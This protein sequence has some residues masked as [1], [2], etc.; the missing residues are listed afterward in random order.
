M[1]TL[2]LDPACLAAPLLRERRLSGSYDGCV[3][4]GCLE[5]ALLPHG[6]R[7]SPARWISRNEPLELPY[8]GLISVYVHPSRVTPRLEF[9]YRAWGGPGTAHIVPRDLRAWVRHLADRGV[10]VRPAGLDSERL[11][12]WS[13]HWLVH[14]LALAGLAAVLG[15]GGLLALLHALP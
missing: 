1:A 4:E 14:R 13:V 8:D 3:Y 2:D 12:V 15:G 9:I 6:V 7:L 10:P 5:A 11:P